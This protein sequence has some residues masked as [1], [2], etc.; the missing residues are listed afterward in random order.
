MKIKVTY[1]EVSDKWNWEKFC[2]MKWLDY[3]CMKEFDIW[4]EE[5]E[6]T[7]EEC[8]KIDLKINY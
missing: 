4:G 8:D 6:L 3:Y 7:L 2:E 1:R 5:V